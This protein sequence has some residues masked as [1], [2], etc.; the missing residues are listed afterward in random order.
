MNVRQ[1]VIARV[2][3][4]QLL[5]GSDV[6]PRERK[7]AEKYYLQQCTK[8][9]LS[10]KQESPDFDKRHPRYKELVKEYG[11]YSEL[12]KKA[13]SNE[14]FSSFASMYIYFDIIDSS[15]CNSKAFC[16]FRNG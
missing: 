5:N 6:R 13:S 7:D 9:Q 1:F 14:Q 8:E 15:S 10:Q 4:L 16:H 12:L 2:K 11:D 3:N